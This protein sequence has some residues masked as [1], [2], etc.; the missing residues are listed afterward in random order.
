MRKESNSFVLT[1]PFPLPLPSICLQ[2]CFPTA[3]CFWNC[4]SERF[5]QPWFKVLELNPKQAFHIPRFFVSGFWPQTKRP[6]TS[7]D[8]NVLWKEHFYITKLCLI[9]VRMWWR[10]KPCDAS[11]ERRGMSVSSLRCTL[12]QKRVGLQSGSCIL[13]SRTKANKIPN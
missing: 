10:E 13:F 1:S 9:C 5:L 4:L 12:G 11:W 6:L 8:G 2:S 3:H 7:A